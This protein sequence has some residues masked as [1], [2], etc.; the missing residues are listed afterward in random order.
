MKLAVISDI[1]GNVLA[2][3][4]VLEKT[5]QG[6]EVVLRAVAYDH[7]AQALAC[8]FMNRSA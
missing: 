8:G 2:L 1:H 6:W 3:R 7:L 4:V 5:Y